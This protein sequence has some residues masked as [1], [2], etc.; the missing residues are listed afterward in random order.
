M[1]LFNKVSRGA[2]KFFNKVGHDAA[3]VGVKVSNGATNALNGI[4]NVSRVLSKNSILNDL[5][6]GESGALLGKISNVAREGATAV[7]YKNYHGGVNQVSNQI[8]KN[9]K[10]IEDKA[11]FA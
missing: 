11:K 10:N 1:S 3:K 9:I 4:E 6:G 5:T 8:Q 7:N 2:T